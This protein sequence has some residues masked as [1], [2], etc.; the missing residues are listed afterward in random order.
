MFNKFIREKQ[1]VNRRI[2]PRSPQSNNVFFKWV[3]ISSLSHLKQN[4]KTLAT[5]IN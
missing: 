1:R 5:M 2:K 4:K 3:S